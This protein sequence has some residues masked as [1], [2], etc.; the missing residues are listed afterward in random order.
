MVSQTS[1]FDVPWP[2]DLEKKIWHLLL[3][4]IILLC[5]GLF[6]RGAVDAIR[7]LLAEAWGSHAVQ[8]LKIKNM[9]L[10]L[11]NVFQP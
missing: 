5:A 1:Y 9:R 6:R 3:F 4:F 10:D 8:A 7:K 2:R 11:A